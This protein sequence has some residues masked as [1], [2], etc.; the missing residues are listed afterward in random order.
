MLLQCGDKSTSSGSPLVVGGV[1]RHADLRGL[2]V[3]THNVSLV[4]R[5]LHIHNGS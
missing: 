1:F 3:D 5:S 2:V 4:L